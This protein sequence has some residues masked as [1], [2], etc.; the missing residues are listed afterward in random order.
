MSWQI[1]CLHELKPF[2]S[3]LQT[4]SACR[5]S[6]VI[7][8]ERKTS[9]Y[10]QRS[11]TSSTTW[12]SRCLTTSL[13]PLTTLTSQVRDSRDEPKILNVTSQLREQCYFLIILRYGVIME[14]IRSLLEPFF[15]TITME[16][17]LPQV[18]SDCH[19]SACLQW[20]S[21]RDCRQSRC[22]GRFCWPA[23]AASSW[24][25]G[26]AK[27]TTRSRTSPTVTPWPLRSPLRWDVLLF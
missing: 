19:V 10:L 13:T 4:R 24:T 25:V 2:S 14:I 15:P 17:V 27:L 3:V 11:W 5:P 21:W 20:V 12:T 18:W 8:K 9:S 23:A 16:I 7:W 1:F 6:T 26:K 22:T